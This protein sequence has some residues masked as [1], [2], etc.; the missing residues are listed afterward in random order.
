M[1]DDLG[2]GN[3]GYHNKEN[4]EVQTPNIDYLV[5][6]GLQ[7]N[8]HYVDPECSPTRS[9]FQSGRLPVHVNTNNNDGIT[10]STMGIHPDMTCIASKLK[11]AGYSNH[12]IGKWDAGFASFKQIPIAR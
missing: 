10:D 7:L 2:W 4:P 1:A 6:H 11:E 5:E 3:V 9:S 8:R 12:L